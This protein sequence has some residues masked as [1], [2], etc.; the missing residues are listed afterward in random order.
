[1]TCRRHPIDQQSRPVSCCPALLRS[2]VRFWSNMSALARIISSRS[3]S[4]VVG[5][6][7]SVCPPAF[8]AARLAKIPLI[9]H[10]AN[11]KP[12]IANRL[13]AK[14][15]SNGRVGI[16]FPDTE[17]PGSTLVGVPMPSD[18]TGLDRRRAAARAA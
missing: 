17:L 13:G 11:A 8:L 9:V 5:V 15:T 3:I 10:E 12:G 2:P 6:G 14:L 4:A 18:I 1:A 7:G 16:T